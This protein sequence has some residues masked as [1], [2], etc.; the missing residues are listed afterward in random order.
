MAREMTPRG[1]LRELVRKPLRELAPFSDFERMRHEMDRLWE[2][3]VEKGLLKRGERETWFPSLDVAE[4][5][6]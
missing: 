3:Y 5:K 2:T 4:T 1:P 6:N